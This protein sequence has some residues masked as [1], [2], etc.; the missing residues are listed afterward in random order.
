MVTFMP[1]HHCRL[2]ALPVREALDWKVERRARA[3]SQPSVC[4]NSQRKA[5][6]QAE[7]EHARARAAHGPHYFKPQ[8]SGRP[9]AGLPPAHRL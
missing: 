8:Y 6:L 9:P 4:L 3:V 1:W 5:V 2:A 7:C